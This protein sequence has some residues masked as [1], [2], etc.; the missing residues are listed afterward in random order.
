[1]KQA[2]SYC[3][4]C[5]LFDC[6]ANS[7]TLKTEP[8]YFFE[9]ALSLCKTLCCHFQEDDTT[10]SHHHENRVSPKC[11]NRCLLVATQNL[12]FSLQE[13]SC[14]FTML[15]LRLGSFLRMIK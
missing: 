15:L 8:V 6:S 7:L 2:E 14:S 10:I 11:D 9:I 12:L 4:Y 1:V 5:L 3:A 13:R